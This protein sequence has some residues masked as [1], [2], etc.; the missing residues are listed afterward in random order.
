MIENNH[1]S[2]HESTNSLNFKNTKLMANKNIKQWYDNFLH[3]SYLFI[4]YW[5][6]GM[7]AIDQAEFAKTN[8]DYSMYPKWYQCQQEQ[9]YGKIC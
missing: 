2:F 3:V 5:T 8:Q 7:H 9:L 1:A 6:Q 4:L